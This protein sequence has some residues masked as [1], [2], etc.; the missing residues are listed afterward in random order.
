[1]YLSISPLDG[2][3]G[4]R[5]EGELDLLSAPDLEDAAAGVPR[6][7]LLL[8]MEG[9]TF[10]DSTGVRLLL[11]LCV[12]PDYTPALVVRNPSPIVLR[13]LQM[14]FPGGIPELEVQFDGAGPGAVHRLTDLFRATWDLHAHVAV[15]HRRA[16]ANTQLAL[17]LCSE[18][19][20]LRAFRHE[21]AA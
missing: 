4:L 10:I 3:G 11:S 1:M 18:A 13:I 5:V 6:G 19:R 2:T 20:R 8:D 21:A 9:V 16:A 15:S 14:C 17:Q 7:P 12:D